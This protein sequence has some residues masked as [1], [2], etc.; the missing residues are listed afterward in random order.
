[1]P[2]F[3]IYGWASAVYRY[4]DLCGVPEH[5]SKK[6]GLGA[7]AKVQGLA[8][9]RTQLWMPEKRVGVSAWLCA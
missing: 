6:R 7:M 8:G 5:F 3:S 9:F 1:M 4:S 2:F